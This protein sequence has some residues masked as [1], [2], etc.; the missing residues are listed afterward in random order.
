MFWVEKNQRPRSTN[1]KTNEKISLR[2][3]NIT[4]I[5]SPKDTFILDY[6]VA[7]VCL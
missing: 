1:Q 5:V 6:E 3:S 7:P 2:I 4:L